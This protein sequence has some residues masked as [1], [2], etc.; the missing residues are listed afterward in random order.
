[1]PQGYAALPLKPTEDL[2][3]PT[4]CRLVER[5]LTLGARPARLYAD[6]LCGTGNDIAKPF[7]VWVFTFAHGL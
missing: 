5:R 4:W 1:M 6:S 3:Y 7:C 2:S